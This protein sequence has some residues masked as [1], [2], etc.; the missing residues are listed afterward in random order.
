MPVAALTLHLLIPGCLSLKEKRGRIKP[1]LSHLHR[2][3][4]V[5]CA[6]IDRLDFRDEAV[7]ACAVISNDAVHC[8]RVLQSVIDDTTSH[9]HDLELVNQQIEQ[10][11]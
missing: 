6:E 9:F 7:I 2:E 4:N 3:F 11:S 10:L 5:S 8:R 1:L